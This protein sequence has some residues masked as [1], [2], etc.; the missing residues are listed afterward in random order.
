[1]TRFPSRPNAALGLIFFSIML[2]A[3][4]W[5]LLATPYD[6]LRPDVWARLQG[7][8]ALHWLGTDGFGRDVFSRL[9]V[10]AWVSAGVSLATVALA[11]TLGTGI[12]AIAGYLGGRVDDAVTVLMDALM[13]FP[14]I[15]LA[16]GIL[17]AIG[18][19]PGGVVLALGLAY[20]PSVVRVVRGSVLSLKE[21]EFIDAARVLGHGP[22]RTLVTHVIPNCLT[23]L[24]VLAT[25]MFGNA[26]L[27]E[28]ALSFL[29]AGVPPPAPT[30]GGMLAEGRQHVQAAPWLC[31]FP[32]L[33]ISMAL[34][35]INLLGDA[36][37]D[38]LDPRMNKL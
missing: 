25:A 2:L 24:T 9:L 20:T 4:G 35:G 16:L 8:S 22:L 7:P 15:L 3:A 28:S 33:A 18:P 27:S 10:A 12:G 11:V 32:G 5:G 21:R 23:P 29:G 38:L 34:L 14:A 1:M 19:S 17:A 36:L 37:R 30:W 31:I 6:P 13:S 26:L